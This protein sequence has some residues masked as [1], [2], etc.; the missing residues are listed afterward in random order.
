[1]VFPTAQELK[2]HQGKEHA[3][4]MSAAQ[5]RRHLTVP[6]NLQARPLLLLWLNRAESERCVCIHPHA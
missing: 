6:I 3:E 2:Q 5:R 4:G 1:M